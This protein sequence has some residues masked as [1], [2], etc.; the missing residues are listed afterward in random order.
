MVAIQPTGAGAFELQLLQVM[1]L[2]VTP[3]ATLFPTDGSRRLLVGGLPA[4]QPDGIGTAGAVP[5][6]QLVSW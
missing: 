3:A 2:A 5:Q 4:S 1:A 6:L